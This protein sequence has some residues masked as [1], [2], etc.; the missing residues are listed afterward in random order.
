MVLGY[1]V[2]LLAR[3]ARVAVE[4]DGREFHSAPGVFVQDRVRQNALVLDGWVVLRFAAATVLQDPDAV[5]EQVVAV[6]RRRR[7]TRPGRPAEP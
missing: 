6:V 3:A 2:N 7:R 5:A 4:V 1:R